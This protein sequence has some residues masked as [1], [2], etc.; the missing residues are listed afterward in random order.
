MPVRLLCNPRC[1]VVQVRGGKSGT[2]TQEA[3]GRRV[4]G[5]GCQFS[6]RQAKWPGGLAISTHHPPNHPIPHSESIDRRRR[7]RRGPAEVWLCMPFF[8]PNPRAPNDVH[9]NPP[10]MSFT[11]IS[12]WYICNFVLFYTLEYRITDIV[13][14]PNRFTVYHFWKSMISKHSCCANAYN[15]IGPIPKY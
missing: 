2:G 13:F 12:L 4:G 6:R 15:F 3:R 10:K 11:K 1:A 5:G 9:N 14:F 7:R 8:C